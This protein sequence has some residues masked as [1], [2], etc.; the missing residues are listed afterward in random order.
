MDKT[1]VIGGAGFLGS[2]VA[3][4]LSHRGYSVAVFDCIRSPW[5]T[6][7]QEMIVGSPLKGQQ[8]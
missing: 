6:D 1:V 2:H 7:M 3:D 5:V 8:S 4:E